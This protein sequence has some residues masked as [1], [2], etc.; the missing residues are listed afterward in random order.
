MVCDMEQQHQQPQT[1]RDL[2]AERNIRQDAAAVLAGVNQSTISRICNGKIK[3][4]PATIAALA[5][6][7]GVSARRMQVLCDASY[8][9][10]QPAEVPDDPH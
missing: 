5:Q 8:A 10:L 4:E 1:L 9:A 6:A 3:A 7:L 2:L